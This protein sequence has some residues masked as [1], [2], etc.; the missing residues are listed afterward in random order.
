MSVFVEKAQ[1]NDGLKLMTELLS[2]RH[3]VVVVGLN[4]TDDDQ[5]SPP[6]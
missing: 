3:V 6:N 4:L 2:D 1:E 5:E